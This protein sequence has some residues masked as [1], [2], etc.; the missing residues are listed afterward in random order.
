MA[1]SA[2]QRGWLTRERVLAGALAIATVIVAYTAFLVVEP[3]LAALTW[4]LVFAILLQP[5]HAWLRKRMESRPVVAALVVMILVAI[6]AG[7]TVFVAQQIVRQVATGADR[8][9]EGVA[10]NEWRESLQRTPRLAAVADWVEQQV[11][12]RRQVETTSQQVL[13]RARKIL[14]QSMVVMLGVLVTL[15]LLFYFLRDQEH[16]I[17]ALRRHL[18]LARPEADRL[19]AAVT[20]TVRGIVFGTLVVSLLQG[21]LGGLMFWW[22]GLPSP[23]V[24]GTVMALLSI[25][26]VGGAAIV[27]IPAALMLALNGQTGAALIL[28][29]WGGI[30][31]GLVDNV[32]R[33]MLVKDQLRMHTVLVF[34][35]ILGGIAAF[36]GTGVVLGPIVVAIVL[37]LLQI[38]RGRMEGGEAVEDGI[39]RQEER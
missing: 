11:D 31:I 4:A 30:V 24:W 18:P 6:I 7:P 1:K 12:F 19:F 17:G 8:I 26:P 25:L 36:G 5:V 22:L 2:S 13:D 37:A 15:Y 29:A 34:I 21:L 28:V 9:R 38:W 3:F 33:P 32:V 35:A 20:N 10:T 16:M 39:E 14:A 23:L 27:W